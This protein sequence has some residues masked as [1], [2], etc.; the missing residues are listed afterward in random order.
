[1]ALHER[2][3]LVI[4]N[5]LVVHKPNLYVLKFLIF[6]RELSLVPINV[7]ASKINQKKLYN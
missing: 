2:C 1:M 6:F 7:I 3:C 5:L 4:S